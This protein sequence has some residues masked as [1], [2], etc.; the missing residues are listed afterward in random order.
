ML[1][2]NRRHTRSAIERSEEGVELAADVS[3]SEIPRAEP[4]AVERISFGLPR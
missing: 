1:E 2:P 4:E 3:A